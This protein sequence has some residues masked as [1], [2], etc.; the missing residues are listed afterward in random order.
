MWYKKDPRFPRCTGGGL[1][2]RSLSHRGPL[3]LYCSG[4]HAPV[5]PPTHSY[6]D[7]RTGQAQD[8][9][10]RDS[11]EWH[12]YSS[13][14]DQ[15]QEE[16]QLE[17]LASWQ[18]RVTM[19]GCRS[20]RRPEIKLVGYLDGLSCGQE[21]IK[22]FRSLSWGKSSSGPQCPGNSPQLSLPMGFLGFLHESLLILKM[23]EPEH[24]PA[25]NTQGIC[26]SFFLSNTCVRS[27]A[28]CVHS[29][30]MENHSPE[31]FHKAKSPSD[32]ELQHNGNRDSQDP[33]LWPQETKDRGL[34]RP[35]ACNS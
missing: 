23:K 34:D 7:R 16:K 1:W 32:L 20:Y 15:E 10:G 19:P 28:Q 14:R 31:F 29:I 8:T 13:K 18:F 25:K 4:C 17:L 35:P 30:L 5:G 26:V 22:I 21:A 24:L 12:V 33:N 3:H 2:K 11:R 9:V 27:T 6:T